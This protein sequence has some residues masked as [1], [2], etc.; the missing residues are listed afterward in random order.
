MQAP[1][2]SLAQGSG[3]LVFRSRGEGTVAETILATAPLKFLAPDNHGHFAWVFAANFGGGLLE[4]DHLRVDARVRAGARA[5]LGTQS[6]TKVYRAGRG[7]SARQTLAAGVDDGGALVVLPDPV[8]AFDGARYEQES[9]IDLGASSSVLHLDGFTAGRSARGERWRF[10]HYRARTRVFR[11]GRLA[12][13]DATLLDPAHGDL[14]PRLGRFDAFATLVVLGPHFEALANDLERALPPLARRADV[15]AAASRVAPDGAVL[16][17]AG[18]S[19]E[20]VLCAVR[21]ALAG[22]TA[23][24]GDDPFARKW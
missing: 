9:R 20:R 12:F 24:L 14:P 22:L 21:H 5:F 11:Q 19:A 8:S 17:V 7:G 3:Q 23:V 16:R 4:G 15:V 2:A 18:V 1:L 10:A 6:A 13:H